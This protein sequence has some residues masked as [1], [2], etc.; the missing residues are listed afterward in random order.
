[1][2]SS[3]I[4]PSTFRKLQV[5]ELSTDFRKATKVVTV[6]I[7]KLKE[8]HVLVR[9][10]YCGINA[11]DVN[12]TA[13]KYTPGAK[14]PMD[15]GFESVGQVVQV[16]EGLTQL[17]VG[18]YVAATSFGAFAE[19]QALHYRSV[20]PIANG[21]A[22][23]LPL[24]V[25][26]L[27]ASIALEKVGE[28][29]KGDVVLVT[30]AAGGTGLFAVQ[31]AKLAGAHV[32]GTCSSDDKVEVLKKLGCDRVV[33]YKKESLAKVL[34]KEYPKGVD[35]VYESVGG[36]MF[37][38]ALRALAVKGKLIIIGF[39]SGY[40]DGGGWKK[41]NTPASSSVGG[42]LPWNAELLRKSASVRGF[43]LNDFSAEWRRHLALLS[44][45]SQEGKIQSVVDPK[46]FVGL[47]SIAD[48]VDHMYQG[49]NVGKVVV[50]LNNAPKSKL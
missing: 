11:S 49:K 42:K 4:I 47:E 15:A 38:A 23:M 16:A 9:T 36:E 35:V 32:I 48:A 13:G 5:T 31:L 39:I 28:V 6:N 26:G 22:N 1:M 33:N 40:A 8:D 25:S 3:F 44:K 43:F 7:P 17:K 34:T 12:F 18:D 30:A 10:L 24:L 37:E 21:H 27:T 50:A 20:F 2:M 41:D 29:K 45:L 46:S 14:P 19:Y